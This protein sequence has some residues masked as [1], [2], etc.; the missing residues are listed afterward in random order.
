ML[1][2]WNFRPTPARLRP[3]D[4]GDHIK[5]GSLAG[6]IWADHGADFAKIDRERQHVDRPEAAEL[7][8]DGI[9]QQ[10]DAAHQRSSGVS[11]R[12]LEIM[13]RTKLNLARSTSPLGNT[14]ATSTI[15]PDRIK[16]HSSGAAAESQNLIALTRTAPITAPIRWPRPPIATQTAIS[17]DKSGES[18]RG[19][20]MP[21]CGT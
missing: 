14:R 9:N 10:R 19:L 3:R 6:P 2:F 20:M 18:S 11:A 17:S 8:G 21:T 4:A 16:G 13:G 5:Q 1:G 7:D 12:R 15:R